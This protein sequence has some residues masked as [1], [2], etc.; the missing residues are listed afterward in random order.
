MQELRLTQGQGPNP[1]GA[2][3]RTPRLGYN[4]FG[5]TKLIASFF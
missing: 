2:N 4:K 5:K 1:G 3:S